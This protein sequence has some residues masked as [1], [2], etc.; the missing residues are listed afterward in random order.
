MV[1]IARTIRIQDVA[2]RANVSVATITR[3]V[4][5]SGYVSARTRQVVQQA[6]D[7]L[8]YVPNRMASAL[9]GKSTG[10]IGT[11]N[12]SLDI[13]PY[14]VQLSA[15]LDRSVREYGFRI[16]SMV[17]NREQS[18]EVGLIHELVSRMVDAIFFIGSTAVP[19]ALIQ[20]IVD[21]GI[22]VV[23]L[24]RPLDIRDVDRVTVNAWEGSAMAAQ[25][26]LAF[27]HTNIGYV[28]V[29]LRHQVEEDRYEG[30]RQTLLRNGV[31][32]EA[33]NTVLVEEYELTHGYNAMR[34]LLGQNGR[35]TAVFLSS[36]ILAAG[37]LQCLYDAHLRVPDDVSLIGYDDTMASTMSPPISSV[38]LPI[39]EMAATTVDLFLER[40][41]EGRKAGKV[42]RIEPH[43]VDRDT[44]KD[45][46]ATVERT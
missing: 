9:K 30:F 3:V 27:G 25:K 31:P 38:A 46:R 21:R 32:L 11:I 16:L 7:D 2:K 4:N 35:P 34:Q 28:G 20:S 10:V 41:R 45:L 8:G 15:A 13:N 26:F 23:M 6:I 18:D 5:G 39:Q 12:P 29:R 40:K 17:V 44:V 43:L 42:V 33:R 24:E 1:S 14:F 22:P 36:D 37:A 19:E